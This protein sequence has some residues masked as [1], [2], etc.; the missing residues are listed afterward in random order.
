[1]KAYHEQ[2]RW[3]ATVAWALLG[4]LVCVRA[5]AQAPP[6]QEALV[7]VPIVYLSR[8]DT[9][10]S[11]A[12]LIDPV[13]ADYGWQGARFAVDEININGRFVGKQYQLIKITVPAGGDLQAAAKRV[14]AD[15][16]ALIV[17]DLGAAD[18]LSVADLPRARQAIILDAR[19]SDDA[20][21]QADCR[22]NVFHLLPNWAVRADALGQFLARKNW[23]R[24][25]L[26][27]G[28]TATDRSYTSAVRR[29]ASRVGAKIV[30]EA[31]FQYQ[32]DSARAAGGHEQIQSQLAAVTHT[33]AAYDVLFVA[34]TSDAFGE[35]L[36]YNTWDPRPVV[37]T[38]GLVAVAWHRLFREYAARGVQY[39][40]HL[41]ASRD[42]TER[43]YGNWLAVSIIGE[44]VTRSGTTDAAGVRSYLLSDRFSVPAFKGEGLSF[45]GWDHQLRQP[46]LLFGPQMLVSMW[47]LGDS[48]QV[49]FQTDALGYSQQESL[50]RRIQ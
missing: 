15:G 30:A 36:S 38:H 40:F 28:V 4:G 18:L 14:L 27:R 33:P 21:R 42:M 46:V 19:A 50:C 37:G 20:L 12:S 8:D 5:W 23:K 7:T 47:P 9:D 13:V 26:L 24:W 17:A 44:A 11:R 35:Y 10:T 41:A 39:R 25:F 34:D 31:S 6:A 43:D 48:R 32:A 3:A 22:D 45:R 1:M 16:H 49:K 2:G 29:A